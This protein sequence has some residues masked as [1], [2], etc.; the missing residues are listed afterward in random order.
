M[1]EIEKEKVFSVISHII[2]EAGYELWGIKYHLGGGH[3]SLT[4]YLDHKDGVT[5]DC[6]RKISKL[7]GPALD[8][9]DIIPFKYNLEVSSP[10]LDRPLFTVEQYSKYIGSSVK[11][12]LHKKIEGGQKK[13]NGVLKRVDEDKIILDSNGKE[14]S[15]LLNLIKSSNLVY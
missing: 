4:V 5:I 15:L 14:I 11:I 8:V 2:K 1:V 10:G 3:N 7:L 12:K 6:C 13:F 9:E